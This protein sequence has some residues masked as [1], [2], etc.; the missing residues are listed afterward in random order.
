MV[1][2]HVQTLMSEFRLQKRLEIIGKPPIPLYYLKLRKTMKNSNSNPV[3]QTKTYEKS[4]KQNLPF[5][6]TTNG[7]RHIYLHI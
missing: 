6:S 3:T 7:S 4:Q 2:S 5:H 1:D